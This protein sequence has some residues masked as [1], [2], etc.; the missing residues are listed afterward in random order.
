VPHVLASLYPLRPGFDAKTP[1]PTPN[2]TGAAHAVTDGAE[3]S[4]ATGLWWF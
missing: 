2:A 4:D 1:T 3:L